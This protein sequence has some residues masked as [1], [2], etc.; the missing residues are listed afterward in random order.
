[1]QNGAQRARKRSSV[2]RPAKEA[3]CK[4]N[5]I[6]RSATSRRFELKYGPA[7]RA[8]LMRSAN[9]SKKL[10]CCVRHGRQAGD[11]PPTANNTPRSAKS[12]CI[13]R[14]API[15]RNWICAGNKIRIFCCVRALLDTGFL[16]SAAPEVPSAAS[17]GAAVLLIRFYRKCLALSSPFLQSS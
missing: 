13:L 6:R 15:F 5:G 4:R 1:M 7:H 16:L 11:Q 14:F 10:F 17:V 2:E 9:A 8:I 12:R 3:A